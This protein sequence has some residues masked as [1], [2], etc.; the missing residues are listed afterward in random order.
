MS[1]GPVELAVGR[2]LRRLPPDDRRSALAASALTLA[3]LLDSAGIPEE[4]PD[5]LGVDKR[6]SSAAQAAREL[7]GTMTDLLKSAPTARS[8][9]DDL[10]ARRAAKAAAR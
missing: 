10:R 5:R 4:E 8:G 1:R 2:D 6:L 9:I 7:R 3:K